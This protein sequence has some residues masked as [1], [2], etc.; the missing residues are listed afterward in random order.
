MTHRHKLVSYET[1]DKG[2]TPFLNQDN[3]EILDEKGR[4]VGV[5]WR[6]SEQ[7]TA[8]PSADDER[9]IGYYNF[10]WP[11]NIHFAVVVQATRA[12]LKYGASQPEHRFLTLEE[13]YK[14]RDA[15]ITGAYNRY[16]KKYGKEEEEPE[17]DHDPENIYN[18]PS[19]RQ[20]IEEGRK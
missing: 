6:I 13:A 3:S 19:I 16:W 15:L 18:L 8:P 17:E 1:L 20:S 7:L 5:R 14:K 12:G 2:G 4:V 11:D 10:D 9:W